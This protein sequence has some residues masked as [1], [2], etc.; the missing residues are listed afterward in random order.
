MKL[1]LFLLLFVLS[2]FTGFSFT[3]K[4][5]IK[6]KKDIVTVNKKPVFKLVRDVRL[7]L[8]NLESLKGKK[9]ALFKVE[10]YY[11]SQRVE[12]ANP[13]GRVVY[14]AVT[15]LDAT[16][17]KCE[18]DPSTRKGLARNIIEFHLVKD[19]QLN[20][21]AVD[22]FVKIFGNKFSKARHSSTTIIINH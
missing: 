12:Q 8:I 3:Q 21:Q 7:N 20:E 19:G 1:K 13:K 15:F 14:Y 6:I 2:Q 10:D 5:K 17:H 22:Q 11:D 4:N 16:M 9:L 18:L